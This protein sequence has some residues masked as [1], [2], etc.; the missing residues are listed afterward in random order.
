MAHLPFID[1]GQLLIAPDNVY[2]QDG[3]MQRLENT[4]L[5]VK[6]G[7]SPAGHPAKRRSAS[8]RGFWCA[9]GRSFRKRGKLCTACYARRRRNRVYFGGLR[10]VVYERDCYCCRVCGRP[11]VRS[12][13]L[14]VHHRRPGVSDTRHLITLCPA[15]HAIV[16]KVLVLRRWLPPLLRTLWREQHPGAPEQLD[17]EFDRETT[18]Q[19]TSAVQS[20]GELFD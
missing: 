7:E 16:H 17:L 5:G 11:A 20:M 8:Q 14:P 3:I 10:E 18:L 19:H 6:T 4:G 13:S 12:R 2:Y 9:C 15:C 1:F